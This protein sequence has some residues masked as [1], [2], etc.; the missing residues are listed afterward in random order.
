MSSQNDLGFVSLLA[1]VGISAFV[2]VDLNSDGSISP[3]VGTAGFRGCG[4]TQEGAIAGRYINVKLWSAPGTQ[5]LIVSPGQVVT[6]GTQYGISNG[7]AV[8]VA[9]PGQAVAS[10]EAFQAG[11]SA[12]GI[13]LEFNKL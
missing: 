6:P 2:A 5:Q 13:V 10:I 4:V 7:Y 11:V 9:S 1:T 12:S 3:A 8:V